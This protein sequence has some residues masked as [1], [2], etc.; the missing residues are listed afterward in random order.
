MHISIFSREAPVLGCCASEC[1]KNGDMSYMYEANFFDT[2]I[3]VTKFSSEISQ[4]Y[5]IYNTRPHVSS[6][7]HLTKLLAKVNL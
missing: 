1:D 5:Y 4:F 2:Y 3:H 6:L 7:H